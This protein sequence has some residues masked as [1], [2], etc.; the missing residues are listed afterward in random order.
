G[1]TMQYCNGN[2][3]SGTRNGDNGG[4]DEGSVR[5]LEARGTCT[6]DNC[7]ISGGFEDNIRL[8]NNSGTLSDFIISNNNIH[9]NNTTGNHGILMDFETTANVTTHI[10]GNTFSNHRSNHVL[11]TPS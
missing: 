3:G 11:I 8:D 4:Q 10:T 5:F 9:D 7:D 6:I 1:F 2:G